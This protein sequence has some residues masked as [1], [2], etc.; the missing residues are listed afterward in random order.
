[1]SCFLLGLVMFR[2]ALVDVA[3]LMAQL[4]RSDKARIDTENKMVDLKNENIKLTDKNNKCNASI[5][6]L[7]IDLKEHKDRLKSTEESLARLTVSVIIIIPSR[8]IQ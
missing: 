5:R 2:G 1:M 3:K 7:N 8:H 4:D 6:T